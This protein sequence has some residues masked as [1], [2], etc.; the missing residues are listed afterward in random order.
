MAVLDYCYTCGRSHRRLEEA[1]AEA[2]EVPVERVTIHSNHVHDAPL[3]YE[4]VQ[5]LIPGVHNEEY[6]SSVLDRAKQAIT[7][8]LA[9]D[10][11]RVGGYCFGGAP[12]FRFA[13]TRRVLD[14][15]NRC[16]IRWSVLGDT[17]DQHLKNAPEGKI[18]PMLD[19][20]LVYD[21]SGRPFVALSFYATHPQVSSGRLTWSA[22]T[23][24][25]ARDLFEK[26][27]PGVF[28]LHFDG[29]GGD[30]TAGKYSTLNRHRNR[31]VFGLRLYD[32][33]QTALDRAAPE[34]LD[35]IG[36]AN[37]SFDMPLRD[38]EEGIEHFRRVLEDA[39]SE[40]RD[41]YLAGLKY[42]KLREKL[43]HYPFRLSRLTLGDDSVLF[44]PA[45]LCI[46][47]QLHAKRRCANRLAVAA[48]GDCFLNYVATDEA[49]EQGGYEVR[50]IW[51]EVKPGCEE[52][53]KRAIDNILSA[54]V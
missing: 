54:P 39:S 14:E 8:A 18:D 44:L 7:D 28:T 1:L 10:G 16:H 30:I 5:E 34:P 25:V 3:V 38:E 45:E 42:I 41:K 4:E 48:Y 35:R 52:L 19:Q 23:I 46:E 21:T 36:W 49:F 6:F 51:T 50:P 26:A 40:T 12:V 53:I 11:T 17:E 47:Y 15:K 13:S 9:T 29:C 27:N 32:A 20:I 43:S 2:A 31:L 37:Q 33:M 22:D 24:G